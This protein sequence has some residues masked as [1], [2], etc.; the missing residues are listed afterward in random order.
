M[1]FLRQ[2]G[3]AFLPTFTTRKGTKQN[4]IPQSE[5]IPCGCITFH[6]V[7]FVALLHQRVNSDYVHIDREKL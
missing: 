2:T 3:G 7:T 5:S 1:S 4:V 6:S